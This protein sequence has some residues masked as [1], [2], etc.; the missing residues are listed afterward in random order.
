MKAK[1]VLLLAGALMGATVFAE[2][3]CQSFVN[4]IGDLN[5]VTLGGF[6][7][8][9]PIYVNLAPTNAPDENA[10]YAV[11]CQVIYK[12]NLIPRPM[13]DMEF[14][15]VRG[16]GSL[17]NSWL[18][19]F[20]AA[21]YAGAEYGELRKSYLSKK[22]V[23]DLNLQFP[24]Y[25]AERISEMNPIGRPDIDT[26]TVS[27][28]AEGAFR[29]DLIIDFLTPPSMEIVFRRETKGHMNL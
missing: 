1:E 3:D 16:I 19:A 11:R 22:L 18:M 12:D 13:S 15:I 17:L 20:V 7:F 23:E 27:I 21:E 10:Q 29:D 25:V 28:E 26:V 8:A 9:K 4:D 5:V 6:T 24:D 2:Y 14:E